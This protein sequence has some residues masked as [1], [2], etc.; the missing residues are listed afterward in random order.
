MNQ[1][2]DA[3]TKRPCRHFKLSFQI[4]GVVSPGERPSVLPKRVERSSTSDI[5]RYSLPSSGWQRNQK[6]P[7]R[8]TIE[9]PLYFCLAKFVG[10]FALRDRGFCDAA[11]RC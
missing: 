2:P 3:E 11:A 6:P 5:E 1:G 8:R 7:E 9:K 10:Q 4:V